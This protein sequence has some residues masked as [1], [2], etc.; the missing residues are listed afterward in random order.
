MVGML[1]TLNGLPALTATC[2]SALTLEGL[3]WINAVLL[4]W[5]FAPKESPAPPNVPDLKKKLADRAAAVRKTSS[6][7]NSRLVAVYGFLDIPDGLT[8]VACTGDSCTRP[9]IRMPPASFLS[10]EG[11]QELK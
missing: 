3:T 1:T 2:D 7:A 5:Q 6:S 4:P 10:V 9:D 11:F 8:V